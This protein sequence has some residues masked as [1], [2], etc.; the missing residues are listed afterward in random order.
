MKAILTISPRLYRWHLVYP[1][2]LPT[3]LARAG[4]V[5]TDEQVDWQVMESEHPYLC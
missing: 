1:D 4:Q 5:I 2:F 3:V